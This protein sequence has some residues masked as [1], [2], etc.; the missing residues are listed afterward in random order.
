MILGADHLSFRKDRRKKNPIDCFEIQWGWW[1][2]K[3]E[4]EYKLKFKSVIFHGVYEKSWEIEQIN[5]QNAEHSLS[6][7]WLHAAVVA[8]NFA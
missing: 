4:N 5:E 8:D 2:L 6:A 7:H 3:S 1:K